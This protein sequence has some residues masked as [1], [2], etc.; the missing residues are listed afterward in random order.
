SNN[1]WDDTQRLLNWGFQ[2]FRLMVLAERGDVLARI[3]LADRMAPVTAVAGG[4]LAVVVRNR[5]AGQVTT[6]LAIREDLRAPI[7]RGDVIG[8]YYV[9]INGEQVKEIPLVAAIDIPKRTPLRIFW[10]WLTGK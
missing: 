8:T 3:P 4:P 10:R 5:D 9:E 1:R 6:Q 2:E 7:R